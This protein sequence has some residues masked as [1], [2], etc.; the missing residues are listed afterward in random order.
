MRQ[1]HLTTF[2]IELFRSKV[3]P[4]D[5]LV[6]VRGWSSRMRT[7][8]RS[9][10]ASSSIVSSPHATVEC[11]AGLPSPKQE[12]DAQRGD[13]TEVRC[14]RAVTDLVEISSANSLP[15]ASFTAWTEASLVRTNSANVT[16][17]RGADCCIRWLY[18]VRPG[19]LPQISSVTRHGRCLRGD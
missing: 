3:G 7:S 10:C 18:L 4:M 16:L 15:T 13:Q 6:L 17:L 1:H 11:S 19:R 5:Q 12:R 14:V 8:A 2:P 9:F